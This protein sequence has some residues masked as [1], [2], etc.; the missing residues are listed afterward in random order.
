MRDDATMREG[1][2][3]KIVVLV[4]RVPDTA[5]VFK[6]GA[7]GR[8]VDL[9]GLKFVMSPYDEHAV[10]AAIQL[11]EKLGAEV[12][13]LSAGPP[14]CKEVIRSALA[15][16]ADA[17]V[18]LLLPGDTGYASRGIADALAAALKTLE[19]DLILA[20]KQAVDDDAAKVPERVAEL[21]DIPHASVV[22][23]LEC[24]ATSVTVDCE[25][26]GGQFT[27]EMPLPALVTAQKGLNT[28]RY[29]TLPNIMKAKKKEI[30]E[31]TPDALG[32]SGDSLAAGMAVS[33][34]ALPRQQ[35]LAKI[36]DG[37]TAQRVK[38]LVR[39]LRE[40]EKVL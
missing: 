10:E 22:A 9:S 27:A 34:M 19:A 29:P 18:H 13:V 2:A 14:E 37:D 21:L 35:R 32:I 26:E 20:G 23:R 8:S 12:I 7:D 40:D 6:V 31:L 3:V 36:L 15:M 28:P 17:G 4:K 33:A 24:A 38:E 25:V 1:S 11:K 39:A 16:G 30:R 5:S